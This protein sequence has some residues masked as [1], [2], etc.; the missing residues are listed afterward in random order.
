MGNIVLHIQHNTNLLGVEAALAQC[1][2]GRELDAFEFAEQAGMADSV[3][4]KLVL[5]ALRQLGVLNGSTL[6]PFGV[7][8]AALREDRPELVG[9]AVHLRL[10]TL[11]HARPHVRFSLAYETLC[12]WLFERGDFDL[13]EPSRSTL[14]GHVIEQA[15]RVYGVDPGSIA[16]SKSSV[17]GGMIWLRATEPPVLASGSDRFARRKTVA[18]LSVL[19]AVDAL[20]RREGVPFGTRL[21]LTEERETCLARWLLLDPQT[22]SAT[23]SLAARTDGARRTAT[24]APWLTLGTEGGFGA[25]LLL[26][27]PCPVGALTPDADDSD[28]TVS[29]EP[30]AAGDEET[31][32][33]GEEGD[34]ADGAEKEPI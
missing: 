17:N 11:H 28:L 7:R 26:A 19:W 22:L 8:L 4:S 14:A 29:G 2:Y 25:W 32:T 21:S 24:G 34:A 9:E 30:D 31:A 16:F 12:A 13:D 6:A 18:A 33:D 10:A 27:A 20:Y 5:P 1:T 15:A 3:A 23:L